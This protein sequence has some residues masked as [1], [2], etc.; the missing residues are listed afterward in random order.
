MQKVLAPTSTFLIACAIVAVTRI[1]AASPPSVQGECAVRLG[2]GNVMQTRVCAMATDGTTDVY[3]GGKTVICD[4]DEKPWSPRSLDIKGDLGRVIYGRGA[5]VAIANEYWVYESTILASVNGLEWQQVATI[6]DVKLLDVAY[7]NGAFMAV[8]VTSDTDSPAPVWT[9]TD[10]FHWNEQAYPAPPHALRSVLFDGY[11]F[12]CVG[13]G[14]EVYSTSD[15]RE[16]NLV[17]QDNLGVGQLQKIVHGGGEYIVISKRLDYGNTILLRTRDFA[18]F[19]VRE[20]AHFTVCTDVLLTQDGWIGVGQTQIAYGISGYSLSAALFRLESDGAW[21]TQA[22][23][24][25]EGL[26]C[27]GKTRKGMAACGAGVLESLDGNQWLYGPSVAAVN[28]HSIIYGSGVFV[29]GGNGYNS[30]GIIRSRD[31]KLWYPAIDPMSVLGFDVCSFAYGEGQFLAFVADWATHNV[32]ILRSADA[33]HWEREEVPGLSFPEKAKYLNGLV[34]VAGRSGNPGLWFSEDSAR[35]W[36]QVPLPYENRNISDF[37]YGNGRWVAVGMRGTTLVS[38]DGHNWTLFQQDQTLDLT[39]LLFA[40]GRFNAVVEGRTIYSSLDGETWSQVI[41]LPTYSGAPLLFSGGWMV[42]CGAKTTYVSPDGDLWYA[43]ENEVQ[44]PNGSVYPAAA[45]D[46][47][48][49]TGNE[50]GFLLT[51]SCDS[52][53]PGQQPYPWMSAIHGSSRNGKLTL[54]VEGENFEPGITVE[55]NNEPWNK[56]IWQSPKAL[57]IKGG[58]KLKWRVPRGV[59]TTFRLVNPS[60]AASPTGMWQRP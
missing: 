46:G 28:L 21:R 26:Q 24:G 58:A 9:S 55:I 2:S 42:W 38:G 44:S 17:W 13:T 45:G 16:W 22:Y 49:L 29:T 34:L 43:V 53:F 50:F 27:I 56:V 33:D 18:S 10:G 20:L 41:Q 12:F 57:V 52:F 37:E 6:P 31:A 60:G 5:F 8:G 59:P 23:P 25:S 30:S 48:V 35:T 4:S 14:G 15:G 39:R 7:G 32:V 11:R 3:L 1:P 51:G 19:D 40:N 47:I 54:S 36:I